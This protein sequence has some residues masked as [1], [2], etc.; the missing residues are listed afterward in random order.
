MTVA[1]LV[2]SPW[3]VV[4]SAITQYSLEGLRSMDA[5]VLIVTGNDLVLQV[6]HH[7]FYN[8]YSYFVKDVY[9]LHTH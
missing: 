6:L 9:F 2:P 4:R 7:V 8:Y 1:E 5:E 3:P